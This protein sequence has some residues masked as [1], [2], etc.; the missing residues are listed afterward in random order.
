M[1]IIYER[2][3]HIFTLH[4][5][6]STY[7]MKVDAFGYLLH[8]YY[9]GRIPGS[10]ESVPSMD[11]LLTYYDRGFSG[12]PS[13]A[14]LDRTYSLDVLPQEYPSLGTGDFRGSAFAVRNGDGSESCSLH[15]VSHKIGKGKYSLEGLP[16]VYAEEAQTLEILLE[17][18]VSGIQVRLL[19]GV[20]EKEDIITRSA[21]VWNGGSRKIVV[22][23]ALSAC[24]DF[25]SGE[26]DLISFHGRH[27]MERNFQRKPIDCGSQVLGSRRGTSSHQCNPA[28]IVAGRETGED[29]G[30]CYGMMFVYSGNFMCEAERDQFGQT[31]VMMGLQSD[32]FHYPLQPGE[33]LALPEVVL[34]YTGSGLGELSRM[35]HGV[36]RNHI[37][38][39]EYRDRIRP[40][41]LNSWEASYFDFN[42]DT[43]CALA[44]SAAELGID[45]VVMDDGW[46]GKREDDNS[47][48]GDW[49]VNEKKLGCTLGEMIARINGC[50][51]KFGIW[52]EPEMVSEDS[53]LYRE[54]PDW[55]L[56]IP[57]REPV[58]SR[59]QLVLDF[60]REEVRNYVFDRIC[61]VLEQGNVE[62]VKWDM[63]R[64]IADVYSARNDQGK[65][66][67]DYVIGVY[68]FLEKLVRRYPHI[69]IEGCSGGGGRFDAGMLYYTPQIWCSDN[70][71]AVDRVRIQYGTSF[72][73]PASTV[74]AHVSAVP[75]HQTGRR[76]CLHTRGVVA[77]AGTF[78]YELDPGKLSEE[79][80]EEV[81]EQVRQ[82]K[83]H[84]PLIYHGDYYR[85]SDP[86]RDA[87]G[88]WMFVSEDRSS[89]LL[90]AV[91]LEIH[92]N[93]PVQY[94]RL[95]GLKPEA[96]YEDARSHQCYLGAALMN[97]G[98]PL[99]VRLEEYAAYQIE[100]N[101]K[102]N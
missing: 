3:T 62:Y 79:E 23:K 77:M 32:L 48:L 63:N 45:M 100:L 64:S 95:K 36:I 38:R 56:R 90:S 14:G 59:N 58:R 69:M 89:A 13:A 20:L 73:Y 12:N 40:V 61:E 21:I 54:H 25:V 97:A 67:Y 10:M 6:H 75:N 88:A 7:Q 57:G 37:C 43:I 55:A 50:G 94:V 16:A 49:L 29:G 99:P 41:L 19:Y 18:S 35:F 82:F 34:G 39:G 1:A 51:V 53:D 27:A 26:Y 31:R 93:M 42:A 87:F 76:T 96:V 71:D 33:A 102:K 92:G 78:G 8:L 22:E 98:L 85:L 17:D 68:D 66:A 86:F 52:I 46:F 60:S 80:K 5:E 47:G 30:D 9:G 65:V 72:F 83:K 44:E 24:V 70:T 84:A 81:R 74:G 91:M 15:Y 28:V 2:K 101:E 4:T 11:Y